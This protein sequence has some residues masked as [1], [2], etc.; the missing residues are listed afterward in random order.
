MDSKLHRNHSS[1][2]NDTDGEY[3]TPDEFGALDYE[4]DTFYD[5]VDSYDQSSCALGTNDQSTGVGKLELP[6][7]I[8]YT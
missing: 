7:L 4:N 5:A 3:V 1:E 6:I 8:F 2:S